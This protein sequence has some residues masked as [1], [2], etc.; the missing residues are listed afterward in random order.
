[1]TITVADVELLSAKGWNNLSQS[2]KQALLDDAV[3][4]SETLYSDRNARFPTLDGDR[5]VFIKNLAAHKWE[6]A[7]GGQATSESSQ[8]GSASFSVT[9]SDDYLS[10]THFG[11]TARRHIRDDESVA[12]IRSYP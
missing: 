6:L 10:L 8:G 2:R 9:P 3:R 1:M 4:E 11:E 12:I 5:D 7:E